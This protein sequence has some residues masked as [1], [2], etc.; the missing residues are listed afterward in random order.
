M[1]R[2]EPPRA[3]AAPR[4]PGRWR[5]WA[6]VLSCVVAGTAAAG[7]AGAPD[8]R[9]PAHC[10][11]APDPRASDLGAARGLYEAGDFRAA[12]AQLAWL[13]RAADGA[14]QRLQAGSLQARALKVLGCN[15]EAL[16]TQRALVVE[17]AAG[18]ARCHASS[19]LARLSVPF[20]LREAQGLAAE[21]L[22]CLEPWA[23]PAPAASGSGARRDDPSVSLP[24]AGPRQAEAEGSGPGAAPQAGDIA[25]EAH[26]TL[27]IVAAS[28]A[29]FT[30]AREQLRLA[31]QSAASPLM[32]AE[33]ERTLGDL[34]L[35]TRDAPAAR[36]AFERSLAAAQDARDR[37]AQALAAIYLADAALSIAAPDAAAADA[38]LQRGLGLARSG[39]MRRVLAFARYREG[40]RLVR[41]ES[42]AA[43]QAAVAAFDEAAGL[44][45]AAADP[46]QERA[47]RLDLGSALFRLGDYARATQEVEVARVLALQ[48]G[49]PREAAKTEHLLGL[50]ARSSDP[51]DYPRA[52]RHLEAALAGLRGQG[53]SALD[54]ARVLN[55]L[56][57]TDLA[58]EQPLT[59]SERLL[60]AARRSAGDPALRGSV[61]ASLGWAYWMQ[62]RAE[63]AHAAWLAALR[64][65]TPDTAAIAWWGLARLIEARAP[66]TAL[67]RYARAVGEVERLLPP[68]RGLDEEARSAFARRYSELYREYAGLLVRLKR[69]E[70][71]HRVALLTQSRELLEQQWRGTR[72]A[73]EPGATGLPGSSIPARCDPAMAPREAEF[74]PLRERWQAERTSAREACCRDDGDAPLDNAACRA[75]TGLPAYCALRRELRRQQTALLRLQDDCVAQIEAGAGRDPAADT[76]FALPE[77]FRDQWSKATDT[78]PGVYL[79]VTIVEERE[80]HLLLRAPGQDGYLARSLPVGRA[81]LQALADGLRSALAQAAPLKNTAPAAQRDALLAER[82]RQL[83]AGPL[84]E[85]HRLL[86]EGF[87]PSALPVQPAP[88]TVLAFVLDRVLRELPMA[89]LFD[90]QRYLGERYATVIVTPTTVAATA[91]AAGAAAALVMG[92]SKPDLPHVEA[93]VRQVAQVLGQPPYLNED[94]T[95]QR[96]RAWLGQLDAQHPALVLHLASH[97]VMSASRAGSFVRLWG[98]DDLSGD[99]LDDLRRSLRRVQL[100]AFS[101]CESARQG[102]GELVL[103]LAG[104]AEKGARS[105]LGSLWKVDDASTER[106]MVDFYAAWRRDPR[107]GVAQALALAQRAM[108]R[109]QAHPYFWAAFELIGRWD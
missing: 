7:G 104:L 11:I 61:Q 35:S 25:S 3:T 73:E 98:G 86:L 40:L 99:D 60:D 91:A 23:A 49:L 19:R 96:L 8:P 94:S 97:A 69:F 105:V 107:A 50:I 10:E 95:E 47:V 42:G 78:E 53:E 38:A 1:A 75:D 22:G 108:L 88:G 13:S 71:A 46:T 18:L 14:A 89:A 85:L 54:E 45:A 82:A 90:G 51:P 92:V 30:A 37:E 9:S 16:A 109:E 21:A 28:R 76:A 87:G 100:V 33:A 64:D 66:Q 93:E 65:T 77:T 26:T 52:R 80:L 4:R 81:Q 29:E 102:D 68:Q 48:T 67:A 5:A 24:R 44:Y 79:L 83:Q 72:G 32:R 63:E 6:A 20:D 2:P 36:Q 62:G 101:A 31:L 15:R 58:M 103:G 57:G 55:D 84:R 12:A 56:A 74:W 43:L 27:A 41:G 17:P 39:G 34:A 59:A 106:L 70:S